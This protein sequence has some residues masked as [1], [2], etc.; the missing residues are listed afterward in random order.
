MEKFKK[1]L[2]KIAAESDNDL[3]VIRS[4]LIKHGYFFFWEDLQYWV[5]NAITDGELYERRDIKFEQDNAL[6][7]KNGDAEFDNGFQI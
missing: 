6:N 4:K 2:H 7:L 5:N 3:K 1:L